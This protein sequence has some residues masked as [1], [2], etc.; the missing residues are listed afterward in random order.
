MMPSRADC[1]GLESLPLKLM[2]VAVVATLSIIPASEALDNLRNK[3]FLNRVELQLDMIMSTAQSLAIGGPGGS[4]T[5]E[6]DFT[7]SG[8]VA[9]EHLAIGGGDGEANMSSI[10]L[11]FTNGAVML[12]TCSDPPIWMRGT[13]G[14]GLVVVSPRSELKMSAQM[15]GKTEYILAEAV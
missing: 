8:S 14:G 15:E 11:R 12:K 9:F 2:I 1:R 10:V 5:I 7:S 3:D 6:L 4:R 13:D